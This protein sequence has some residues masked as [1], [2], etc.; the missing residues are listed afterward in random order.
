MAFR[1]S[2]GIGRPPRLLLGLVPNTAGTHSRSCGERRL[3]VQGEFLRLGKMTTVSLWMGK[4]LLHQ[5][6][7][8][9]DTGGWIKLPDVGWRAS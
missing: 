8:I 9:V 1:N 3:V 7:F 2:G 4:G 5:P 6:Y